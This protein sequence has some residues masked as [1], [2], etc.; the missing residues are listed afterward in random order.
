MAGI[1]EAQNSVCS[2]LAHGAYSRRDPLVFLKYQ[3]HM[4]AASKVLF[5]PAL[6][7]DLPRLH[8]CDPYAKAHESRRV[9]LRRMVQ[10]ASCIVAA[11]D[12]QQLGFAVL[13]YNFFGNGFISLVCVA[14]A[15]RGK[16]VALS[17]VMELAR[18]CV[19]HK[20][21]TST[22]TSNASAQR[23]FARAGF[24]RSGIV[25]NLDPGDPELV[26]F[27]ASRK[28]EPHHQLA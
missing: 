27:K 28:D 26:F 22:N 23:L 5:R 21:F 13:E 18:R 11:V 15:H 2:E 4:L 9:E 16:G 8:E 24:V 1:M 17:L 7:A 3:L 20:L 25:E 6:E 12:D 14:N 19:T 10:Q